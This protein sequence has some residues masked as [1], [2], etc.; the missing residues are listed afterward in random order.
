MPSY[1]EIMELVGFRS[2]NA[3]YRLVKRLVNEGFVSQDK[4]GR[5][6]PQKISGQIRVLGA[7]EAGF[8]SPA[9]EELLDTL[10]L[11]D[12][13]VGNKEGIYLLEVKGDSM[14]DAGILPG[15]MV[16]AE[17][18]ASPQVGE[19]VVAE[20]DG[21]WTL[22]YLRRKGN[23]LYLEAANEKYPPIFPREDLNIVAV[24]KATIRKYR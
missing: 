9:E 2:K 4:L 3:V 21:D 17:R 23:R 8:P 10:S 19:I 1:A 15:D 14:Q 18:S 12:F 22:K 5:L 20:I 11:D 24:V 13:L 6:I 16:L 7:I